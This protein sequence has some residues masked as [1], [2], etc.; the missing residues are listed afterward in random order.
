MTAAAVLAVLAAG[1]PYAA[2]AAPAAR[3]ESYTFAF[4]DADIALVAEEIL[5]GALGVSYAIDPSVTG[6]MSFRIDR[7]LTRAQL[8]EAFEAALANNGVVLIRQGE[9]VLLTSRSAAKGAGGVRSAGDIGGGGY[10]VV[11]AP[12]AH[13]IPSEVA[14]LLESVGPKD[15]VVHVDD[16]TGT[17]LIGGT[18]REIE[19]ALETIKTFDKSG[20]EGARMRWFELSQASAPAIARELNQVLQA[21]GVSGATVVPLRRL[22]GLIAFARTPAALDDI[23]GWVQRLDRSGGSESSALW[24]YRPRN[25][26]AESLGRTLASALPGAGGAAFSSVAASSTSG[27]AETTT[28]APAPAPITTG[29]GDED[30]VRLGVDKESNTLLISASPAQRVQI[31]R[32]LEEIDLP[33]PQVLI[34][35]SILEVSLN[36]DF[37]LGVNWSVLGADGKLKVTSSSAKD[38]GVGATFP[39]F[40]VTFIDSD[41]KAAIDALGSKTDVEVVSNPKI[42][43]LNNR[44]A[45]LQIGD[46][47][48]IVVQT[49]QSNTTPDAPRVVNV[50]YRDTGVILN[51]TPRVSGEDSV[52]LT[53]VQEASSVAKTTTSGI[54]SPTIQQRKFESTLMLKDGGVVALG[55]LISSNRSVGDTGLPIL[56]DVPVVGTLFKSQTRDHR[57]TELIVL[58]SARIMRSGDQTKRVMDDL[59]ADMREI[60]VRGLLGGR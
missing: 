19:A 3:A 13:A 16:K 51:V 8:L 26:S 23:A 34:E 37:R 57:R 42:V 12:V 55:G 32:I 49:A 60:G 56:K 45:S 17:L 52:M 20:M 24:V 27:S 54:D 44:T 10:E 11:S 4:R 29:G 40:A 33:P 47:V 9:S 31:Q 43:A 41:I 59:Q 38:G 39:G 22:N 7:R 6:K 30:A 58:I 25:V 46:Q 50:E 15:V 5:G 48:P 21:S 1:A 53:V 35:A 14:K 28:P 36:N 18:R 2:A